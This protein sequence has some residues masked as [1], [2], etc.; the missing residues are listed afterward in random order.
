MAIPD[1]NP[2]TN[3]TES[4]L[5][6]GLLVILGILVAFGAGAWFYMHNKPAEIPSSTTVNIETPDSKTSA[7]TTTTESE[8]VTTGTTSAE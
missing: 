3:S 1:Q 4:A 8:T 6:G 5:S 2:S 7:S